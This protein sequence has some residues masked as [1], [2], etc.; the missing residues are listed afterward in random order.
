MLH[1]PDCSSAGALEEAHLVGLSRVVQDALCACGFAGVNVC[2]DPDIS[3]SV[4]RHDALACKVRCTCLAKSLT[5]GLGSHTSASSAALRHNGCADSNGHVPYLLA[6]QMDAVKVS[7]CFCVC[8]DCPPHDRGPPRPRRLHR[9][10][11]AL[12]CY[13]K[14]GF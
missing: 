5:F 8:H 2:A 11:S 14:H 3:I 13:M 6:C 12:Q 10:R 7:T 9:Q 1:R 4:E